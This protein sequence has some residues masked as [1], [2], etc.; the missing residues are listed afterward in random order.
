MRNLLA[1][2]IAMFFIISPAHAGSPMRIDIVP[3]VTK[4][5]QAYSWTNVADWTSLSQVDPLAACAS[6]Y[7]QMF[8]PQS[9]SPI[10][11]ATMRL[12]VADPGQVRVAVF[13]Y[14]YPQ[15]DVVWSYSQPVTA[16]GCLCFLNIDMWSMYNAIRNADPNWQHGMIIQV[17]G[18]GKLYKATLETSNAP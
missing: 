5:A 14:R 10:A 1:M 15:G 16:S 17:K 13:A 7:A 2:L 11:W 18:T 6:C 3:T 4:G 9:M 12:A 8:W